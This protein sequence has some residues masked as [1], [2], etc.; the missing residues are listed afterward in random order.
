MQKIIELSKAE[1]VSMGDV[2]FDITDENHFWMKW[3][4]RVFNRLMDI[5]RLK[6]KKN[7]EIGCGHGVVINQLEK[8]DGILVDGCDLN[9]LALDQ[10][11]NNKGKLFC[12]NIFDED[13]EVINKYDRIILFDVIEH[14]DDEV[15]FLSQATKHFSSGDDKLIFVNVPALMS[16]YSKYD[17]EVGHVRRYDK[18][19]LTAVLEKAGFEVVSI[20]YWGFSLLP[21]AVIRKM[22]LYFKDDNILEAGMK[23]PSNFMNTLLDTLSKFENIF[24]YFPLGTSLMAV[25]R[26]KK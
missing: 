15:Q 20:K 19:R 10:I 22:Y 5:G 26:F 13:K 3:R 23:P 14:I 6:N 18:K 11:R 7:F 16:L 12:Y 25:A 17:K 8:H 2:W 9:P 24:P 1:G 4:F 21:I